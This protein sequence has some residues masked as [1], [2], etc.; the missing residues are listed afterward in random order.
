LFLVAS[1]NFSDRFGIRRFHL[2]FHLEG[3]E[4]PFDTWKFDN[5][6][7]LSQAVK[8]TISS[9]TSQSARKKAKI[10]VDAD[11]DLDGNLEAGSQSK[12]QDVIKDS[13]SR[14]Y[15]LI[16]PAIGR[17]SANRVSSR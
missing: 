7:K 11:A 10:S 12:E 5:S 1:G 9:A 13:L 2:N 14:E 17:M 3:V 4:A 16:S 8:S 15:R 6:L